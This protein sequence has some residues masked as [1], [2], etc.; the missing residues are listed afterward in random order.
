MAAYSIL[1][2]IYLRSAGNALKAHAPTFTLIAAIVVAIGFNLHSFYDALP[3]ESKKLELLVALACGAAVAAASLLR[4]WL[5]DESLLAAAHSGSF[6]RRVR[7]SK[8]LLVVVLLFCFVA[9]MVT[10]QIA[11]LSCLGCL[12]LWSI[13]RL[14]LL[15]SAAPRSSWFSGSWTPKPYLVG[16]EK[17]LALMVNSRRY[18]I[19]IPV[20][21]LGFA[22]SWWFAEESGLPLAG[23]V[24]I[25]TGV[26][27]YYFSAALQDELDGMGRFYAPR[28][29]IKSA[30]GEWLFWFGHFAPCFVGAVVAAGSADPNAPLLLGAVFLELAL[31]TFAHT[32]AKYLYPGQ[33][34]GQFIFVSLAASIPI[35]PFYFAVRL[36]RRDSPL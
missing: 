19:F 27:L 3:D 21:V 9:V 7:L 20:L 23:V 14:S 18:F 1:G 6:V 36:C 2:K 32:L 26:L 10:W 28:Y 34:L 24:T 8:L 29:K 33:R 4:L 12:G 16:F 31:L 11:A 15:G 13:G 30:V 5:G 35:L 22:L 17:T 25:V